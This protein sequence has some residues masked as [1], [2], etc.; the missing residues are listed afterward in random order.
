M[1]SLTA[2]A[3]PLGSLHFAHPASTSALLEE[4]SHT[5]GGRFFGK[6]PSATSSSSA[7]SR[8]SLK[9]RA[10]SSAS[11]CAS[12]KTARPVRLEI[13]AP[14]LVSSSNPIACPSYFSTFACDLE[15]TRSAH[16]REQE[17]DVPTSPTSTFSSSSSTSASSRDSLLLPPPPYTPLLG[18]KERPLVHVE[19]VERRLSE[20]DQERRAGLAVEV[21]QKDGRI[22]S[23]LQRMGL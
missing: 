17:L 14:I 7:P 13:S 5:C 4:A 23:E 18:A 19:E 16:E 6:T 20:W 12:A 21:E 1:N 8:F 22:A 9:K 15:E 2:F 3:S 11:S 10:T